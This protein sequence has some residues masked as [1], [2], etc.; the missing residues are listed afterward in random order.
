MTP[1][2]RRQYL[3]HELRMSLALADA[4]ERHALDLADA[5]YS[6]AHALRHVW[7]MSW[8][9]WRHHDPRPHLVRAD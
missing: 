5:R 3:S 2:A 9:H 6:G 7:P 8:P 4:H 1:G